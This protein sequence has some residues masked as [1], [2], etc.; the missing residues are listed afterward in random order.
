MPGNLVGCE[1]SYEGNYDHVRKTGA[2]LQL[3]PWLQKL[4]IQRS[5]EEILKK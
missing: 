1:F 5:L 3:R 4:E 2:T